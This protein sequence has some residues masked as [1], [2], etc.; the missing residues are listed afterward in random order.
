MPG[1]PMVSGSSVARI[2]PTPPLTIREFI[3][4]SK[5]GN[6]AICLS[7][8]GSRAL[9]AGIGE[10]KALETVSLSSNSLLSQAIALSTVSGGS[11]LGV[12]F[13]YLPVSVSDAHFLGGPYVPP[14]SSPSSDLP[15]SQRTASANISRTISASPTC[16]GRPFFSIGTVFRQTCCGRPS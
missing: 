11:W 8:G 12:P 6:V 9:S 1:T 5:L 2:Y 10:L 4:A 7:G 15:P 3:D 13:V 16:Y 14:T